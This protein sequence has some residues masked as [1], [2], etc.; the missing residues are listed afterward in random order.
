[1]CVKRVAADFGTAEGDRPVGVAVPWHGKVAPGT[2][3]APVVTDWHRNVPRTEVEQ[4]LD[5]CNQTAKQRPGIWEGHGP[6]EAHLAL[7]L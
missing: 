5:P 7:P 3:G 6:P 2:P 4:G 1:M